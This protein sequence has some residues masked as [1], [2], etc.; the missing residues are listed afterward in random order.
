MLIGFFYVKKKKDKSPTKVW[1]ITFDDT[2]HNTQSVHLTNLAQPRTTNRLHVQPSSSSVFS[3]VSRLLCL[4]PFS[5]DCF[6]LTARRWDQRLVNESSHRRRKP[7]SLQRTIRVRVQES[8]CI[9]RLCCCMAEFLREVVLKL[10][11]ASGHFWFCFLY[12]V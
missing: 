10:I 1:N 8:C 9:C 3:L 12:W 11:F 6:F 5:P 7:T 4:F 2:V